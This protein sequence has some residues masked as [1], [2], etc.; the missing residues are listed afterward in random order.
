MIGVGVL[1][2]SGTSIA[3]TVV[4]AQTDGFAVVQVLTPGNNGKSSFAY[5]YIYT[6]G[7]WFQVQGG[8]VGSFGSSWNPVMNNNPNSMC[9]PIQG[10]TN[11][12][13]SAGNGGGNQ[14][15][16]PIQIFWFP[17][18]STSA[19]EASYKILKEGEAVAVPPPPLPEVHING[20]SQ[21]G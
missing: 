9:I 1:L 15:N 19:G 16:S 12:Q 3:N 17:M 18:G 13:Y 8:T 4:Y 2:A 11:W 5:G 6:I 10:G 7:T 14:L 20:K 21:K